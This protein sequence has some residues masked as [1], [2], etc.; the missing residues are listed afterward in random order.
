M[1]Q[2]K[3][4][5]LAWHCFAGILYWEFSLLRV[6]Y[7]IYNTIQAKKLCYIGMLLLCVWDDVFNKNFN[8]GPSEKLEEL[9]T[10]ITLSSCRKYVILP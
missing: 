5:D 4:E 1:R 6:M 9:E 8:Q 10:S 3:L 2:M 7:G